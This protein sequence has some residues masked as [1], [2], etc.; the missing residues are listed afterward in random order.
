MRRVGSN[1]V[2]GLW[3]AAALLVAV[4]CSGDKL[5]PGEPDVKT[6]S[7]VST[8]AE[9]GGGGSGTGGGSAKKPDDKP[10]PVPGSGSGSGE[11]TKPAAAS[12]EEQASAAVEALKR[13]DWSRLAELA[14]PDRGIRF[15]PYGFVDT[16]KDLV[17]PSAALGKLY[18]DTTKYE[19]GI[20]EG[21]GEPIRLT[22]AEY[23]A[24]FIYDVDFAKPEQ[25]AVNKV[26]G[27]GNMAN[28]MSEAYPSDRYAFVEYHFSG[29]DPKYA[30]IDWKSLRLVFEK[31]G[32]RL[33]LIGIVHDQWTI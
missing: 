13:Q 7:G 27:K 32:G 31:D 18:A 2:F 29:F 9:T 12:V 21:S 4:A 24:K 11:T 25:T 14:H 28:N 30:G 19:W 8:P 15:S 10:A 23:Y 1:K 6:G 3:M 5:L 22:F 17:F 33:Y 26:V 16:D 20:Y